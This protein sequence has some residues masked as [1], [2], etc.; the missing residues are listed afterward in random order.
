MVVERCGKRRFER[1]AF[2]RCGENFVLV[3]EMESHS[4]DR[5]GMVER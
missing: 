4:A 3:R 5:W 1:A 2:R